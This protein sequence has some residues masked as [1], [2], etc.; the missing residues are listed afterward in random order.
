MLYTTLRPCFG[1]LKEAI[2]AGITEIV[3]EDGEAYP[4]SEL[5]E[6]YQN[7]AMAH[8][9]AVALRDEVLPAAKLAFAAAVKVFE[10]GRAGYLDVL[11]AQRTL[12]E[13]RG[14]H[15]AA[16]AAYHQ[17][18][19]DVEGLTAAPLHD[20]TTKREKTTQTKPAAKEN[21]NEN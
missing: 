21:G 13:V 18:I 11:D 3:F 20:N 17:A 6:A 8:G 15:L 1:C 5:E 4:S 19:A 14:K 7:L 2:Q 9:E 16:L 12:I 10:L